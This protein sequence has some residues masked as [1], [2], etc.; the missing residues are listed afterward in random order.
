MQWRENAKNT[1][2]NLCCKYIPDNYAKEE[3][4]TYTIVSE[5]STKLNSIYNEMK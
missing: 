2:Y 1:V 4:L 3:K 5:I